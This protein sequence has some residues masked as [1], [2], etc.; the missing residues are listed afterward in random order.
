MEPETNKKQEG[1]RSRIRLMVTREGLAYVIV[2]MFVAAAAILRNINLL[3]LLNGLMIGPLLLSWRIS[4]S[5]LRRF[6][7]RRLVSDLWFA[8][9]AETVFWEL[10]NHRYLLPAWQVTVTDQA[11]T[12]TKPDRRSP[13]NPQ[14]TVIFEE[15]APGQ[16]ATASYRV[17][18]P[19]RGQ[20]WLGPAKVKTSFPF[21]L[22]RAEFSLYDRQSVIVA[23]A[24]G[25]LVTGW[26]RR[27]MSVSAGDEA[28]KRRS[29][30][31]GD[32]F[33]AVRPWR[34]GDSLRYLH[35]RSTAKHNRPMVRQFDRRSD[36]DVILVL[37]LW[38]A[39]K[40]GKSASSD[41]PQDRNV[42]MI[43]SFATAVVMMAGREVQGRVTVAVSGSTNTIA[44]SGGNSSITG[45]GDLYRNLALTDPSSEP[46]L[47]GL[48]QTIN[49]STSGGSPVYVI[50]TR[51]NVQS[52]VEEMINRNAGALNDLLPWIRYLSP[53][54]PGFFSLF[55][56]PAVLQDDRKAAE[57]FSI[58]DS[59]VPGVNS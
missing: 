19:Q 38:T 18:F 21:G 12:D 36:R 55:T 54:N 58:T 3:I 59:E 39:K 5:T 40:D 4:R 10:S 57:P 30:I 29:G 17:R 15:V 53:D 42:E 25:R 28:V 37:D 51:P 41:S 13:K 7:A 34:N 31:M 32:E 8:G 24:P 26:D 47:E 11:A 9:R 23:P 16:T 56:P 20:Y 27:L 49:E 2:V 45:T 48:F 33:Y 52:V 1:K 46:D 35:W 6:V 43:L 14:A 44:S 22:V 50:S